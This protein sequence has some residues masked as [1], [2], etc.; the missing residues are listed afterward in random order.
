V[1]LLPS[2][3][4]ADCGQRDIPEMDFS[5]PPRLFIARLFIDGFYIFRYQSLSWLSCVKNLNPCD[6]FP[7][8]S[9]ARSPGHEEIG[10][11]SR[12]MIAMIR[13]RPREKGVG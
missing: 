7:L 10:R 2:E 1:P 5:W 4:S 8:G 11:A 13:E 6:V 9:F 12:K 3:S